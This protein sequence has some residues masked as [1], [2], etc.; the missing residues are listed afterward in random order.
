MKNF[1]SSYSEKLG[2]KIDFD[3]AKVEEDGRL[4][5]MPG[6]RSKRSRNAKSR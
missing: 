3:V 4:V 2:R 5:R 6:Y 1:L